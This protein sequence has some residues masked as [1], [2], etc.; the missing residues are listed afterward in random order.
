MQTGICGTGA[1]RSR[2]E[3]PRAPSLR[4]PLADLDPLAETIG[5]DRDEAICVAARNAPYWFRVVSGAARIGT[6][7]GGGR[8]QNLDLLIPGDLFGFGLHPDHGYA[9]EAITEGTLV[10][11]YPRWS[12]ELLA[13][14]DAVMAQTLRRLALGTIS[15]MQLRMLGAAAMTA[16]SKVCCILLD[17]ADRATLDASAWFDLPLGRRD[18][19]KYLGLSVETLGRTLATLNRRSIIDLTGARR[20]RILHREALFAF[21]E[22][23]K[24]TIDMLL[25]HS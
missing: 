16:R 3:A 5:F 13:E 20:I 23:E 14:T 2:Q 17:L 24:R 11:R 12:V 22:A 9:V 6:H 15:R 1:A 19:A 21:Q 4:H 10:A 8:R 7:R 18:L 25:A